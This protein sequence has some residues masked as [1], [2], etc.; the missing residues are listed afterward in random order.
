MDG[1]SISLR[2]TPNANAA[3]GNSSLFSINNMLALKQWNRE[4]GLGDGENGGGW[5]MSRVLLSAGVLVLQKL[6]IQLN[7]MKCSQNRVPSTSLLVYVQCR[8]SNQ[9]L[10]GLHLALNYWPCLDRYRSLPVVT[11]RSDMG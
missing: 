11:V 1:P 10:R 3:R 4:E 8:L 7:T 5:A 2:A 6:I 9:S